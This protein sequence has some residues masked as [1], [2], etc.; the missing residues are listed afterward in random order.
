VGAGSTFRI[1]LPN[2]NAPGR[3]AGGVA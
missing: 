2:E 3:P 1:L